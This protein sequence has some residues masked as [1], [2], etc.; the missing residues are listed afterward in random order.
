MDAKERRAGKNEAQEKG[1]TDGDGENEDGT[2][3][4]SGHGH[5][6]KRPI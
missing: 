4:N 3:E 5:H 1:G 6:R 2:L